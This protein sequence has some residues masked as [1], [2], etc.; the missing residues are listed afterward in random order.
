MLAER[1]MRFQP[2]PALRMELQRRCSDSSG[3]PWAD[4]AWD[5]NRQCLVIRRRNKEGLWSNLYELR[6]PDFSPRNIQRHDVELE[7]SSAKESVFRMVRIRNE[8]GVWIQVPLSY[9][10]LVQ[11]RE[12]SKA[13]A[14][15]D[16][17]DTGKQIW[18][19][20]HDA[21]RGNGFFTA[22]PGKG[23][24]MPDHLQSICKHGVTL[25]HCKSC[26]PTK[27]LHFAQSGEGRSGGQ[28]GR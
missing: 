15:A 10:E 21:M 27:P 25:G 12:A 19:K 11:R 18:G 4:V 22:L 1:V 14:S 23:G 9:Y 8:D 3:A 7:V 26:S 6:H 20:Y 2:D 13:K 24:R 5:P 17:L 28:K 16:S